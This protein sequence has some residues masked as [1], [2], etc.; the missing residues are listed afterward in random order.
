MRVKTVRIW[1]EEGEGYQVALGQAPT[2]KPA[3]ASE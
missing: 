1:S 3:T 2:P